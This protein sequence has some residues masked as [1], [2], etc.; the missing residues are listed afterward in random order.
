MRF[1]ERTSNFVEWRPEPEPFT[2]VETCAIN[3][4]ELQKNQQ[5]I[6]KINVEMVCEGEKDTD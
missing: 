4:G 2:A 5:G 3:W 6:H 1:P